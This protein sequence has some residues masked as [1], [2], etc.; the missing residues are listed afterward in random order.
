LNTYEKAESLDVFLKINAKEMQDQNDEKTQL[1]D[2]EL[3]EVDI[4]GW[5]NDKCEI[6]KEIGTLKC[7]IA[8]YSIKN[9]T[10]CLSNNTEYCHGIIISNKAYLH[11]MCNIPITEITRKKESY[12]Y[13]KYNEIKDYKIKFNIQ[14]KDY[15][16][17]YHGVFLDVFKDKCDLISLNEDGIVE[18]TPSIIQSLLKVDLI[19]APIQIIDIDF[20]ENNDLIIGIYIICSGDFFC[21]DVDGGAYHKLKI[22]KIGDLYEIINILEIVSYDI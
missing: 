16:I 11:Y 22:K 19:Y 18:I 14:E 2:F 10:S 7:I 13:E 8:N 15:K 17:T 21:Y 4:I 5:E 9:L 6:I 20:L 1:K 12:F 3:K